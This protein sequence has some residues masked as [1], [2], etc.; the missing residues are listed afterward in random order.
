MDSA[1]AHARLEELKKLIDHHNQRYYQ[2][3]APEITDREYDALY[4]ELLAI[5]K[6]HP[7]W[8]TP[9]SPSQRVGETPLSG[10]TQIQHAIPMMSL[11]NTYSKTE[12]LDFFT[13]TRK[14]LAGTPNAWVVEPKIDG[15]AVS[16]RYE[17]GHL[18]HAVTRGDGKTGDNITANVRTIR[19][20]PLKLSSATPPRILEVRGEVY[21]TRSGFARINREREERGEEPFAN[22]RNA[23]AGSLKLLD[24]RTVATRP[25]DAL[26]YALG[27]TDGIDITTQQQLLATLASFGLRV[28]DQYRVCAEPDEVLAAIDALHAQRHEFPFEI[29]GAVIKVNELALYEQLGVTAK[30]PRWAVA[31]KYEPEQAQ[32]RLNAITIQVGRTGVLTPVAELEPVFLAGSTISRATLHNEDEIHRKDIRIGDTV[33]IEKAGEVIPAVV[34]VDTS[35]RT[36]AEQPFHMP[37]HCP[38]CGEP[39]LRNKDEVAWRCVNLQCPAQN[40]RRIEHFASRDAMDIQQLGSQVAD[41][42]VDQQLVREPL[43]LYDLKQARLER[44]NLG[45]AEEVRLFGAKNAAKLLDALEKTKTAPLAQWIFAFGIPQVGK[46]AA[47]HLAEKHTDFQHFAQQELLQPADRFYKLQELLHSVNP[48]TQENRKKTGSEKEAIRLQ[49][50]QYSAEIQQLESRLK[51]LGLILKREPEKPAESL[52]V[53]GFKKESIRRFRQRRY[54]GPGWFPRRT[55]R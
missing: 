21:M 1:A 29:D 11:A 9:D 49:H 22:P 3:S 18:V 43:D 12:L 31:Y 10:F 26:W 40:K 32:T 17:D 34:A 23:A 7:D 38:V 15:L 6:T 42:L 51:E 39:T 27:E 30:S 13:R 53:E 4:A 50:E 44:L 24:A 14:L 48:R 8:I 36:G 52:L 25:L 37:A 20:V 2:M 16:L 54:G 28:T 33:T 35:A 19:T 41:A 47:Y 5:E 55:E 45:S 46:T